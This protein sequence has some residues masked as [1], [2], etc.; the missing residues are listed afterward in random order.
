MHTA[1]NA[2]LPSRLTILWQAIV[3]VF[4]TD[5]NSLTAHTQAAMVAAWSELGQSVM[6]LLQLPVLHRKLCDLTTQPRQRLWSN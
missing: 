4:V 5:A 6:Q 1:G 2:L 3:F